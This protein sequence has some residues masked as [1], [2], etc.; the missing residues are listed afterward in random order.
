MQQANTTI[1]KVSIVIPILGIPKNFKTLIQSLESQIF[2]SFEVIFI[3]THGYSVSQEI[4]IKFSKTL[5]IKYFASNKLY[6]G[7]KRNIGIIKSSPQTELVAF[8]DVGTIP[9]KH[10]L[11]DAIEI[12]EKGFNVVFGRTKYQAHNPNQDLIRSAVYG[13]KGHVT[14][15]GTL[16]LKRDLSNIGDF[17]EGI[18]AGEDVDWKDRAL[19]QTNCISSPKINLC[20]INLP[21]TLGPV[22]EKF[23]IYYIHTSQIYS[24]KH[25]RDLYLSLLIIFLTLLVPQWNA[26]FGG[27]LYIPHVTKIYIISFLTFSAFYLI[28]R[29]FIWKSTRN[30]K[31]LAKTLS[32]ISFSLILTS[33]LLW[34]S[35]IATLIEFV[36][37]NFS[38]VT[39]LFVVTL[40]I[41]SF[42]YRGIYRPLLFEVARNKIFP[43]RWLRIGF[44]G[45]LIDLA[46]FMGMI[47]GSLLGS[48]PF[49]IVANSLKRIL[50][51][52]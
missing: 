25:T 12:H 21:D 30:K 40:L 6:P 37:L 43:F 51:F 7:E 20:Y 10:W 9:K 31:I 22:L 23:L 19:S 44:V 14:L 29:R 11:K 2:K 33:V 27:I 32:L 16:V 50:T 36:S 4:L 28:A 1:P 26:I 52:K 46:K 42:L 24:L 34:N 48:T 3:G 17:V 45:L 15:P 5:C 49:K 35:K 18:R 41:F 47:I 39:E 13:E 8:L 38:F